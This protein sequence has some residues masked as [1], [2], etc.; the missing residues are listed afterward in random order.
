MECCFVFLCTAEKYKALCFPSK[1]H[2]A[3]NLKQHTVNPLIAP[4]V[5]PFMPSA[6]STVSVLFNSIDH[7]IS[8][9]GM[10]VAVSQF[11]PN[12]RMHTTVPL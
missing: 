12:V 6:I 2:T 10:S 5:N 9:I 11:P 1:T 7:C 3:H 4:D 8:V